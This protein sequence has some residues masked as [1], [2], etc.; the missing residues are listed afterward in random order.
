MHVISL[1]DKIVASND[2]ENTEPSTKAYTL[3]IEAPSEKGLEHFHHEQTI[4]FP[5]RCTNLL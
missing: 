5:T 3:A 1:D 4:S 2:W